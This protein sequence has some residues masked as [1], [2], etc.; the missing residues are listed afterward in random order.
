MKYLIRSLKYLL[1]F[2][3]I[4]FLCIA[5][6]L[7]FSRQP[8]SSFPELFKE[9]SLLPICLIFLFFAA[10][11]PLV[12]YRKGRLVMDGEWKDYRDAIKKTMEGADYE[13]VS[14]D[15]NSLKFR[16]KRAAIRL[17]RMWEDAITFTRQESDPNLVL[18]D[19]PSRDSLRLVGNVYYNYRME[20]PQ[21]GE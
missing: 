3:I 8:I 14:E 10:I 11:Y 19:G 18:V 1:Y 15:E 5:L 21:D 4:F 12:G 9:G 2:V 20:H 17:T 13:L 7:L 16:S 6:V